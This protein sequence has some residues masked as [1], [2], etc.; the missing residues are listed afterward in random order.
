M[1]EN[2]GTI[3]GYYAYYYP[4]TEQ[5]IDEV[6]AFLAFMKKSENGKWKFDRLVWNKLDSEYC[7]TAEWWRKN[8]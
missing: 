7:I 8:L 2:I 3:S 6:G 1:K 5:R 4:G